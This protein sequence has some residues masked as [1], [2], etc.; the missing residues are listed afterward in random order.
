MQ[1]VNFVPYTLKNFLIGEKNGKSI[2]TSLS[3][4]GGL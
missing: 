4:L 3:S 2:R 1:L